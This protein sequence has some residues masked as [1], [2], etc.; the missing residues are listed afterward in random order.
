M[1]KNVCGKKRQLL[2]VGF[3]FHGVNGVEIKNVL[4][5]IQKLLII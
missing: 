2:E 3:N 5:F 1:V 4:P